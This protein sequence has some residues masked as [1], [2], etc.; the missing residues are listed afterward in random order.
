MSDISKKWRLISPATIAHSAS[1]AH[2]IS[3]LRDAQIDICT[4]HEKIQLLYSELEAA[5]VIIKNAQQLMTLAQKTKLADRNDSAGVI[6]D[7]GGTFRTHQRREILHE[8]ASF[9]E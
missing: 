5:D 2:I 1:P 3:V 7:N 8:C 9:A 4:L 6:G